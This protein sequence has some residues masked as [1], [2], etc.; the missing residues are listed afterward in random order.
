MIKTEEIISDGI[1]TLI[2]EVNVESFSKE[3]EKYF[4][5]RHYINIAINEDNG[6]VVSFIKLKNTLKNVF[7]KKNISVDILPNG[8]GCYTLIFKKI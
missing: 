1:L 3:V 6:K 7:K 5:D 2:N 4:N 8:K